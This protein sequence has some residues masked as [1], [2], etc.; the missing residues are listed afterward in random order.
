MVN[1]F[2]IGIQAL[3]PHAVKKA[4]PDKSPAGQCVLN[5]IADTYH[6][7]NVELI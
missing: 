1:S 3:I 2:D 7:H 4:L 6:R 5:Q